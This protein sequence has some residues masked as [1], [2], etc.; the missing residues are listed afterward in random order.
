MAAVEAPPLFVSRD[1]SI[2][3]R[4]QC[5][6][7][8]GARSPAQIRDLMLLTEQMSFFRDL[9]TELSSSFPAVH[10]ALCA[11]MQGLSFQ[12]GD[13]IFRTS[14]SL[15]SPLLFLSGRAT[16]LVDS[17]SGVQ[18]CIDDCM[19]P[20]L[21]PGHCLSF[22]SVTWLDPR[23]VA[24]AA[25]GPVQLLRLPAQAYGMHAKLSHLRVLSRRAA[26]LCSLSLLNGCGASALRSLAHAA[27]SAQHRPGKILAREGSACKGLI[28]LT[29][30]SASVCITVDG[31]GGA[32]AS[33]NDRLSDCGEDCE[34]LAKRTGTDGQTCTAEELHEGFERTIA[35]ISAPEVIGVIDLLDA[36]LAC[37]G[38][39]SV[40][41]SGCT[42]MGPGSLT[43]QVRTLG[44]RQLERPA[45]G[46]APA[47]SKA[48]SHDGA[49]AAAHG[50]TVRATA[51]GESMLLPTGAIVRHVGAV[52]LA[53]LANAAFDRKLVR[54]ALREEIQAQLEREAQ[55][56]ELRAQSHM[57]I[58][59][60]A[61]ILFGGR[62]EAIAA[63]ALRRP[64][65][66]LQTAPDSNENLPQ[67]AHIRS[68]RPH[69]TTPLPLPCR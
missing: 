47:A 27:V 67:T 54:R 25:C 22:A 48:G 23:T 20:E 49:T 57:E 62:A 33:R 58:D 18:P 55:E 19:P 34:S 50:A 46:A 28:V 51:V 65:P 1:G 17:G 37:S 26:T 14:K 3:L 7:T 24:A 9:R 53:R 16:L 45:S 5:L 35:Q 2:M 8:T 21:E 30:G 66:R 61:P 41:L 44:P 38:N 4:G 36:L 13:L 10:F 29:K 59:E 69:V 39:E 64:P 15:H 52:I 60:S 43:V 40:E 32:A 11:G 31:G 63:A 68:R 12:S 6:S 56:E 42:N